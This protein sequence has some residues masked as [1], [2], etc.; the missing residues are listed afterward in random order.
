M[1]D[2]LWVV[3]PAGGHGV[4]AGL[5]VPKQ[6]ADLGGATVLERTVSKVLSVPGVAGVVIAV[7]TGDPEAIPQVE[8][9]CGRLQGMGTPSLPVLLVPG[10]A[11]RQDSVRQAINAD[12]AEKTGQRIKDLLAQGAVDEA[13]RLV[14]TNAIYFNAAWAYPFDEGGTQDAPFTRLDGTA[15]EAPMMRMSAQSL[16]YLAGEGFQAVALPYEGRKIAMVILLPGAGKFADF[17]AGLDGAGLEEILTGLGQQSAQVAVSMPRFQ[18]EDEFALGKTLSELGMKDAFVFGAADFSGMD[19]S[20]NL[21]IGQ[22][23]H[24]A[25]VAVD[26]KGTEAAAASAVVMLESAMIIEDVK[27]VV[28]DRPFIFL[29]RH[30]PTGS[31]LFAGRVVDP[32]TP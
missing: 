18:M 9:A 24:K 15:T 22:V 2:P 11:T 30:N 14:L 32:V 5:P 20:R 27:T 12:I 1:S 19:G 7:P 8:Q 4:R 3:I 28:V 10:G 25:F 23:F 16:R 6:F 17:E 13:T 29:I 26:E 31:I 21:C